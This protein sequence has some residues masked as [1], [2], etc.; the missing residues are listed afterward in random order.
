M[1][2]IAENLG[3][4]IAARGRH[5][6]PP[7]SVRRPDRRT[8]ARRERTRPVERDEEAN[9]LL[10]QPSP[11][12]C[13]RSSCALTSRYHRARN[14]GGVCRPTPAR[15][16]FHTRRFAGGERA[17]ES[18]VTQRTPRSR[19]HC[20]NH[21]MRTTD[22]FLL[23]REDAFK[24][25]ED[26]RFR[27]RV[28]MNVGICQRLEPLAEREGVVNSGAV[29]DQGA[30]KRSRV[31]SAPISLPRHEPSVRGAIFAKRL[32]E[33]VS[34]L[35]GVS[36]SQKPRRGQAALEALRKDTRRGTAT[37]SRFRRIGDEFDGEGRRQRASCCA[38]TDT[39]ST[40]RHEK[41][42]VRQRFNTRWR[43]DG[44]RWREVSR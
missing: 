41:T 31:G 11:C 44:A 10:T 38:A 24:W 26:R 27:L 40:G 17:P 25:R 18:P 22:G 7:W 3:G 32:R 6:D 16:R 14:D 23:C 30:D 2:I 37:R 1:A 36:C 19:A 43:R 5:N 15:C 28:D 34:R 13:T 21:N 33:H 35:R 12:P 9:A 20:R 29:A 8:R 39:A 4:S 42:R